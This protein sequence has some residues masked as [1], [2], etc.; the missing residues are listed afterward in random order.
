MNIMR[1]W[2]G[3]LVGIYLTAPVL[4]FCGWLIDEGKKEGIVQTD[5]QK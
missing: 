4:F 3:T 5:G 1:P 2:L